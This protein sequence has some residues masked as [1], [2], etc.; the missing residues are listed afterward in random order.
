MPPAERWALRVACLVHDIGKASLP[1]YALTAPAEDLSPEHRALL[2]GHATVGARLLTHLGVA[3]PIPKIVRHHHEHYDGSG[4]P[5]H[6]AA[7]NI[8][9]SSRILAVAQEF[10]RLTASPDH[11]RGMSPADA[12]AE[13]ERGAGTAF[14]PGI[15]AVLRGVVSFAEPTIAAAP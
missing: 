11:G 9:I 14:D 6:L 15:V 10:V 13:I 4:Q 8:P 1:V 2:D 12:L 7:D 3:E 5:G